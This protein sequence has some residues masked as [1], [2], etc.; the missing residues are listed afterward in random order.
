MFNKS[1]DYKI[2]FFILISMIL[3]SDSHTYAVP[4][5]KRFDKFE[6]RVIRPKFFTKN[7]RFELGAQ[8]IVVTNQTF[9]YSFLATGLATFHFSESIGI[10]VMGAYGLSIDKDDKTQLKEVFEINTIILRTQYILGGNLLFTPIYGKFQT[11]EG[12]LI[13]FD[14]FL[15]GGAGLV[16]IDFKYDHCDEPGAVPGVEISAPPEPQTISYLAFMGGIG[17]RFFLSKSSSF[18]W[19]LRYM[20]YNYNL[21]DGDCSVPEEGEEKE[22]ITSAQDILTIQIGTSKFF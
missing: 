17:Q 8:G 4:Q 5:D 3:I 9:I 13:Y 12:R 20:R 18:R 10:E 16:G 6:V 15:S 1:L 22:V 11:D 19:D 7:T 14:T 21:A 2:F